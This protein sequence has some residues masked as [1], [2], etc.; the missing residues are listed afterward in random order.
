MRLALCAVAVLPT[1][2]L[3]AFADDYAVIIRNDVATKPEWKTVADT[4]VKKHDGR[5]LTYD[6]KLEEILPELSTMHP[7]HAC[8]VT[9]SANA[10]REYVAEVHQL[11][12]KLDS[13][14][15]TDTQW[16]ILTGFDAANALKIARQSKPLVVKKVASGTELALE[17]CHEG[18]WYDELV[19]NKWVKKEAGAQARE[20]DGPTDTTRALVDSL[21]EYKPDLFVTSGH[22]TERNWMIGFTYKNGYFRSKSGQMFGEDT[23]G[24][25]FEIDSPNPKVYLPIGNCLMGHIDGQDAMALAWMNDAGVHQMIGYTVPTWFGYSGW[26]VLDYFVEQPG[27]YTLAEAFFANQH[28]LIHSIETKSGNMRGL[29]F[30]RDVVAFYGDPAWKATMEEARKAYEQKLTVEGDVYT[31]ELTANRGA[32]SFKPVNVNGAQRG[33]R[34]IVQFLPERVTDVEILDGSDLKPVITDDFVLI[35]N[36]REYDVSRKYRV[37]FRASPIASLSLSRRD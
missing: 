19:K 29:T 36:P 18:Q 9:P 34:P 2:T 16:G 31:L 12:R 1:L 14:P 8:F 24:Q 11:T 6:S 32:D 21:N 27:R 15:Y 20:L 37:V 26:G 10:S 17:M 3:S 25:R 5:L 33:W 22:A 23:Q 30:D 13:D 35:P 4:L 7:R 28:A